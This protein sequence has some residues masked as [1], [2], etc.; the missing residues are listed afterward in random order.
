MTETICETAEFIWPERILAAEKKAVCRKEADLY[1]N[2]VTKKML[3]D[4]ITLGN[5]IVMC[6]PALF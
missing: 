3:F 5:K 1:N 6:K 2:M 4:L